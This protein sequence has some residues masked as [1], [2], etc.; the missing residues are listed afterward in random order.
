VRFVSITCKEKMMKTLVIL[1]FAFLSYYPGKGQP[2]AVAK[3][4][5][6]SRIF[7]ENVVS[8]GDFEFNAS[9]TP[10]GNT[11][12]FSRATANF[13]YIVIYRSTRRNAN[14][15]TPAPVS[16][17]GVYRDTDPFVSADGKR[18]YFSSDR[19]AHGE[20]FKDYEYHLFV[21][22]LT[23]NTVVSEPAL[24][25]LPLPAGVKPS[26]CSFARNGNIYFF[27]VDSAGDADIYRCVM[28][29]GA[30]MAPERLGFNKSQF[31]DF[32]AVIDPDERFIIFTSTNRKGYGSGDLWVS[33]KKDNAWSEPLNLGAKINTKGNDNAPGLSPDGKT[34]YFSSFRENMDRPVYKG[35][36]PSAAAVSALLH[37][38]RNGMRNIYSIDISD[39]E[40]AN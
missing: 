38:P 40:G 11:L 10:D 28:K 23:G 27:S 36:K 24:V 30:Y 2:G 22:A 6:S 5:D 32:D 21:V 31:F 12:Y 13:G 26:Y 8:T 39:L 14:W 16:F 37:S 7:G 17:T 35:G 4:A 9:F 3:L 34:L 29:D 19:P 25:D 18:L 15:C 1:S 33:F 20:P